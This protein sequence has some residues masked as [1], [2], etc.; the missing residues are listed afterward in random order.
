MKCVWAS[1]IRN[2]MHCAHLFFFLVVSRFVPYSNKTILY[3]LRLAADIIVIHLNVFLSQIANFLCNVRLKPL[4]LHLPQNT[5]HAHW[6][7][8]H[9]IFKLF[10]LVFFFLFIF[11]QN[12]QLSN[13]NCKYPV[14]RWN[15][16]FFSFQ[17]W[18]L[19]KFSL[20]TLI[21]VIQWIICD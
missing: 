16:I 8:R 7:F 12:M 15:S 17:N 1:Y 4:F 13:S 2:W 5:V 18:T 6:V 10:D 3:D 20:Y 21:F 9:L 11:M 19:F 14:W